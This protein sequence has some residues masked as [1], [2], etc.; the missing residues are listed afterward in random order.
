MKDLFLTICLEGGVFGHSVCDEEGMSMCYQEETQLGYLNFLIFA[1]ISFKP[2]GN[3]GSLHDG[4]GFYI[5]ND[6]VVKWLTLVFEPLLGR[7]EFG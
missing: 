4:E 2:V 5:G 1:D 3:L 6:C 7:Y